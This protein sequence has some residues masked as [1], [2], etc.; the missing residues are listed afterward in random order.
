MT[1][2]DIHI[3]FGVHHLRGGTSRVARN[4]VKAS[5]QKVRKWA[6]AASLRTSEAD[7]SAC[8]NNAQTCRPGPA[9]DGLRPP[10]VTEHVGRPVQFRSDSPVNVVVALTMPR[11]AR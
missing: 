8:K 2:E 3:A 6:I 9:V 7:K 11:I 5:S 10:D 4:S 1:G